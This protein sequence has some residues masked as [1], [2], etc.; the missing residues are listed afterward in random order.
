M[1][2]VLEPYKNYPNLC[3][4]LL[5]KLFEHLS[6]RSNTKKKKRVGKASPK[7]DMNIKI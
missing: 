6:Q 5:H 4:T 2:L 7:S 3:R 1:L